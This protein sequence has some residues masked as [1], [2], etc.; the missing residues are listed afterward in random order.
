MAVLSGKEWVAKFKGKKDISSLKAEFRLG[1]KSFISALEEAGAQVKINATLRPPERA[2]L[3][4]WAWMI[5]HQRVSP[6]D[7]PAHS[8]VDIEWVH[9]DAKESVKAASEMVSAYGMQNLK[10]APALNSRHTEGRAIDMNISW[11]GVLTVADKDKKKVTIKTSP[12][13]GMNKELH[14]VGKTY[15]VI[16]YHGGAK[17]KPH[18][19]DDGR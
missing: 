11:A 6:E 5:H 12:K 18:W 19:S 15:G 4:H 14:Q 13:D 1:V 16:K 3:M 17:D 7:V 9:S 10:V 8:N 2:Y